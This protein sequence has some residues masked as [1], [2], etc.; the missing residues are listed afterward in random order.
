M[1]AS[2][3]ALKFY[4]QRKL[5][6]KT[7]DALTN[8]GDT[9]T[10]LNLILRDLQ[11]SRQILK[12]QRALQTL[13]TAQEKR[14]WSYINH[15]RQVNINYQEKKQTTIRGLSIRLTMQWLRVS[16]KRWRLRHCQ[17]TDGEQR[18][19]IDRLQGD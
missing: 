8:E 12:T 9:I 17:E 15:W 19:E 2:F 4:K 13:K 7:E 18:H 16:F 11:D 14:L 6:V 1:K 3:D 10:D 5:L